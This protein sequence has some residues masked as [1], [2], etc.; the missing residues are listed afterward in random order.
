MEWKENY[1]NHRATLPGGMEISLCWKD[2]GGYAVRVDISTWAQYKNKA[3]DLQT[4]KASGLRLAQKK[5]TGLI[6]L[7]QEAQKQIEEEERAT[8]N[9]GDQA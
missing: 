8:Q 3:S 4:A 6:E 1:N 2:G 5:I 7:L 9:K